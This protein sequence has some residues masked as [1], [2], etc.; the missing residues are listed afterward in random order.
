MHQRSYEPLIFVDAVKLR[1]RVQEKL[2]ELKDAQ[3]VDSF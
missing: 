3:F 2:I 1:A